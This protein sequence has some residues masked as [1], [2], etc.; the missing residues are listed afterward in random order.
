MNEKSC[1]KLLQ[2]ELKCKKF[3]GAGKKQFT[4]ADSDVANLREKVAMMQLDTA[5]TYLQA[6]RAALWGFAEHPHP[7]NRP[8]TAA[9]RPSQREHESGTTRCRS[10]T[11]S[12]RWDGG[13][14][15]G[16]QNRILRF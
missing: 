2:E 6:I 10:S 15:L 8:P 14:K 13:K 5:H 7:S 1:N 11:C 9:S 4:A 12:S 3:T 16:K